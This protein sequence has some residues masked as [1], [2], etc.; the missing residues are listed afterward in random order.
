MSKQTAFSKKRI[1]FL[2][3]YSSAITKT[4]PRSYIL[5]NNLIIKKKKKTYEQIVSF[6]KNS[7]ENVEVLRGKGE[8]VLRGQIIDIFSPIEDLPVRILFDI[9]KIE[10]MNLFDENNQ[11]KIND[12]EE[13]NLIPSSEIFFDEKNIKN[14]RESF[15]GLKIEDKDEFYKA[16]SNKIIIP[17]SEQF[18]PI[19][20]DKYE[21]IFDFI[22]IL[23][24]F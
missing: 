11:K 18:F 14:F 2:V 15:R 22:K 16:I 5:E 17:G 1:I 24:L 12:I 20:N 13:Y 21:S 23:Q 6:K 10:S 3:S 19:L 4:T 9:D 7:Y 8:Y